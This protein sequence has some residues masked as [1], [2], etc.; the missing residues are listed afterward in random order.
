MATRYTIA[1]SPDERAGL[2]D[3]TRRGR[4]S[5]SKVIHARALLLCDEGRTVRW[6]SDALGLSPRTIEG[7]KKRAVEA[8]PWAAIERKRRETPPREVRYDGAFE[9]RVV[10]LACSEPPPGHARWTVRLLA[11]KL[12]ELR[13]VAE[14]SHM[15]VHRALKKTSF[16]LTS[17]STG[18]SRRG[19]ARPS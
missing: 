19:A 1:L 10:A 13:V 3:I 15:A 11:E 6:V 18:R 5:A 17:G 7:L 9:A 8:G 12:V 14:A 2:E 16:S 4:H